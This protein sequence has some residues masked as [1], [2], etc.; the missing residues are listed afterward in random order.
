M[1][2]TMNGSECVKH[3]P[4]FYEPM[5]CVD[6]QSLAGIPHVPDKIKK[7]TAERGSLQVLHFGD[8]NKHQ[9]INSFFKSENVHSN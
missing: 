9:I 5:L 7:S 2:I 3:L 6:Q 1:C 4:I 8:A